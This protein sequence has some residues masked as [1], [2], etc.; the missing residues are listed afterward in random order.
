MTSIIFTDTLLDD[1]DSKYFVNKWK[2]YQTKTDQYYNKNLSLIESNYSISPQTDEIAANSLLL[3]LYHVMPNM[4]SKFPEII[5]RNFDK[6]YL[7]A[8][9]QNDCIAKK[10]KFYKLYYQ[11]NNLAR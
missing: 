4:Y 7:W 10:I 8:T 5:T 3:E 1:Q 9:L 11:N 6:I 2:L